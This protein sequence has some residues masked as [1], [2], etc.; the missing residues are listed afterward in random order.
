MKL[1]VVTALLLCSISSANANTCSFTNCNTVK[2]SENYYLDANGKYCISNKNR[3][4]TIVNLATTYIELEDSAYNL[5]IVYPGEYLSTTTRLM[6]TNSKEAVA[7]VEHDNL[8]VIRDVSPNKRSKRAA[9]ALVWA[10][11]GAV[12][13][14]MGVIANN[15]DASMREIAAGAFGGAVTGRLSPIMG[16]GVAGMMASGSIGMSAS[17]ACASCH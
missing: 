1:S 12:M 6:I 15:P 16:S 13:G 2:L 17:G 5:N 3:E 4:F 9:P 14:V 11:G 8:V 7:S 10:G